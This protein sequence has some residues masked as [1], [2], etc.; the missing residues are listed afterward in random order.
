L[1]VPPE[2]EK[3]L[4]EWEKL[5]KKRAKKLLSKPELLPFLQHYLVAF[6]ALSRRRQ[7]GMSELPLSVEAITL[8]C[9]RFGFGHDYRFFFRCMSDMDDSFLKFH[10]ERRERERQENPKPERRPKP[11]RGRKS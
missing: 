7:F 1:E 4:R 3:E 11:G 10:A 6:L 8:Y 5:N 9:D 2:R